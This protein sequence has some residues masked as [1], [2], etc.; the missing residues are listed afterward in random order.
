MHHKDAGTTEI[1]RLKQEIAQLKE[2][3]DNNDVERL[4]QENVELKEKIA[5]LQHDD[6]TGLYRRKSFDHLLDN[7]LEGLCRKVYGS[8]VLYIIDLDHFK[9][10]ND[11]HGHAVGDE[12]LV[13][14][15][16]AVRSVVDA[17]P[18]HGRDKL[19]NGPMPVDI[20]RRRDVPDS[21][22]RW[23]GEELVAF[24]VDL[25][26]PVSVAEKIR[27][28]VAGIEFAAAEGVFHVTASV[29]FS[30][31]TPMHLEMGIKKREL[32]LS[33]DKAL[34]EAKESGRN[35]VARLPAQTRSC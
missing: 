16:R 12:V 8:L 11:D 13:Q 5:K 17:V 3:I 33:A 23:G 24:C 26:D 34:Y 21:V 6:L 32:F 27:A 31:V 18:S 7:A 22:G 28:T 1:E 20:E 30:M 35:C 10:V 9:K 14:V 4:R 15:A 25:I 2:Y 29:G 19:K